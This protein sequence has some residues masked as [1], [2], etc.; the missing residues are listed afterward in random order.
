MYSGETVYLDITGFG[1]HIWAPLLKSALQAKSDVRVVYVEPTNYAVSTSPTDGER[2]E[3][4]EQLDGIAPIPGFA[5]LSYATDKEFHLVALLGFEGTRFSYLLEQI[6]PERGNVT[7]VI[8]VPGFRPEY[9]FYSYEG[10]GQ[11]LYD[12]HSWPEVRYAVANCPFQTFQLLRKLRTHHL[13]QTVKVAPIGTKP[14]ALGAVLFAI[15]DGDVELVYDH[16]VKTAKRTVGASR[17]LVYHVS[18][19]A[20]S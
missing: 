8:G 15:R 16:P 2:F 17:A 4:S 10:N 3:L 7:P 19:L 6:Q 11:A 9:P 20:S 1:H 14:H 5:S 18:A 13:P 12:S